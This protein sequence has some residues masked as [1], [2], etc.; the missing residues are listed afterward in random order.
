MEHLFDEPPFPGRL[1]L[2]VHQPQEIVADVHLA[3]GPVVLID[4]L[5]GQRGDFGDEF[6][7]AGFFRR[8]GE[9]DRRA[10]ALERDR[11]LADFER[12]R[13]AQRL[14]RAPP[15]RR[16]MTVTVTASPSRPV[17]RSVTTTFDRSAFF[18]SGGACKSTARSMAVTGPTPTV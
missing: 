11:L 4:H 9:L 16:A 7:P 18:I 10:G 1:V 2:D 15:R 3:A 12:L 6:E 8:V 5:A 17:C 14:G 13:A